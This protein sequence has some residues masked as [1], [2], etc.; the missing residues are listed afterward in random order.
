FGFFFESWVILG[1]ANAIVVW[2]MMS[3]QH[4]VIHLAILTYTIVGAL[5]FI[6]GVLSYLRYRDYSKKLFLIQLH[7]IDKTEVSIKI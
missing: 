3:I 6:L 4:W 5:S 1:I 7:D 2:F